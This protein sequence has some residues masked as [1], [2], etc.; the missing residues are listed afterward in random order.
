VV[1][2]PNVFEGNPALRYYFERK[3]GQDFFTGRPIVP[4]EL[5]GLEPW[6]QY[7]ARTSAF[8]KQLG[9]A[10]GISPVQ[11]DHFITTFL[12]GHGRNAL[13][14][15]D[16]AASDKPQPGWD[17][18]PV[19]RRFIK[20]ASRGA[21]SSKAFWDLIG[22]RTGQLEGAA[23]SYRLLYENG[24]PARARE[25]LGRADAVTRDYVTVAMMDAGARRIH[26]MLRARA[27]VQAINMLRREIA[28]PEYTGADGSKRSL[29]AINRRA[30]DDILASMAMAEAR[31]A[32]V[33]TGV[34]GW[35][36]REPF[37][38]AGFQRELTALDPALAEALAAR[39]ADKK[40]IP[41]ETMAQLWP[42]LRQRLRSDG[43][44]AIVIDLAKAAEAGGYEMGG[45]RTPV[46]RE[47]PPV[48]AVQ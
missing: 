1:A 39:F 41:A 32:L 16:W 18:A 26:P 48:D 30:A 13:A 19:I 23:R 14:A 46:K 12:G 6:L 9:E 4:D 44:E 22:N 45:V 21:S 43:S 3:S 10:T 25:F 27:A 42:E 40:V 8:S 15:Y 24:D 7:T 36:V 5:A 11:A 34:R 31:N 35:E 37:D 2:P 20:D 38:M 28:S 17:D 47:K 33:S 29:D